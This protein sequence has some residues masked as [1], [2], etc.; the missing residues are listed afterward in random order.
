M[1]G[2]EEPDKQRDFPGLRGVEVRGFPGRAE[3]WG[4]CW[5]YLRL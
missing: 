5:S 4:V 3:G 1:G 2:P